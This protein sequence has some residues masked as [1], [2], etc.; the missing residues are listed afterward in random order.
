MTPSQQGHV[1]TYDMCLPVGAMVRSAKSPVVKG[2][3]L[4]VHAPVLMYSYLFLTYSDYVTRIGG[5]ELVPVYKIISKF[6]F[7]R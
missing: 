2:E 4:Q 5:G 6:V 7:T 3:Q 1:G